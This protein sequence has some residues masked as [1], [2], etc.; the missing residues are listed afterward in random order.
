M[1][2]Q[3]EQRIV[4]TDRQTEHHAQNWGCAGHLNHSRKGHG[5]GCAN[6]H[7]NDRGKQRQSGG[8]KTAEHNQ[9][10][11]QRDCQ[12]DHLTDAEQTLD[13][14]GDFLRKLHLYPVEFEVLE[15]GNDSLFLGGLEICLGF[16][17]QDVGYGDAA[18]L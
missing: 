2:V 15:R 10:H 7:A 1:A 16:G 13:G 11:D 8:N 3:N 17:E 6:A 14:L 18:I 12:T 9:K 5:Q 4:N